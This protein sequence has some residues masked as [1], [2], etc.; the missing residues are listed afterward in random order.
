MLSWKLWLALSAVL[1]AL[2]LVLIGQPDLEQR[3]ARLDPGLDRKLAERAVHIDPGELL[4][5]HYNTSM[6]LWVLDLRD[7]ADFNLFHIAGARRIGRAQLADREWARALP[8]QTVFVLVGNGEQR[9]ERAWRLL[10]VYEVPNVYILAGGINAWV[11]AFGPD[12]RR[13]APPGCAG[14]ECRRYGFAAAL[15]DRHPLSEPPAL[16]ARERDYQ[17]KVQQSG[18][19]ARKSGGCG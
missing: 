2:G 13:P 10:Q 12:H 7:E 8:P 18:R 19:R 17:E 16:R 4:A 1:A 6:R 15:G 5:L 9:A 14:P 11:A 3:L